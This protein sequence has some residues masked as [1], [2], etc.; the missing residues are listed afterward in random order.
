MSFA[1]S[2]FLFLSVCLILTLPYAV[3]HGLAAHDD[4]AIFIGLGAGALGLVLF[5][6]QKRMK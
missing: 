6:L 4:T 1:S 3:G 5:Y 2:V